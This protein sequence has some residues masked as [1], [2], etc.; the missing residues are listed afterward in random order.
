MKKKIYELEQ[1]VKEIKAE[2]QQLSADISKVS[3]ELTVFKSMFKG[4]E[5]SKPVKPKLKD[6]KS[7]QRTFKT[8]KF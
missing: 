4:L 6:F 8:L 2:K 7:V 5:R 1:N 3:A